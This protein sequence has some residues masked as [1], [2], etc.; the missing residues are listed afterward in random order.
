MEGTLGLR[1]VCPVLELIL[2]AAFLGWYVIG[3]TR[4][5]SYVTA[6]ASLPLWHHRRDGLWDHNERRRRWLVREA[7]PG[8]IAPYEAGKQTHLSSLDNT[9]KHKRLP[10]VNSSKQTNQKL[11]QRC[12]VQFKSNFI[13]PP[14]LSNPF[15]VTGLLRQAL[16]CIFK[17]SPRVIVDR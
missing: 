12:T 3:T 10:H 9:V 17:P 6:P 7:L 15:F 13:R 1:M 4:Y 11:S 5:V 16:L 2:P 14:L 8:A